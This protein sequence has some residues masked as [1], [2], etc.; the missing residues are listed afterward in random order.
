MA[1]HPNRATAV[2]RAWITQEIIIETRP[3]RIVECGSFFGGAAILWATLL[4]HT[5]EDGRVIAIDINDNMG[6]ARKVD[7]FGRR[8][9]F[10]HGST[11]DPAI[12]TRASEMV[13]GC[14][15]MVILDSAHDAPHVLAELRA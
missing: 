2:R 4:E 13:A 3:E 5:V 14:R 12:V 15:T 1:R 7:L 11:I 9:D 10:L 6:E 8:V